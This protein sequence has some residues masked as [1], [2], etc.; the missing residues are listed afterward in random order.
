MF[1]REFFIL[2]NYV[3]DYKKIE[4]YT[5]ALCSYNIFNK[6]KSSAISEAST[7]LINQI[8]EEN[9]DKFIVTNIQIF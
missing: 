8:K 2:I 6:S 9:K 3:F 7:R 5:T 4:G 1:K